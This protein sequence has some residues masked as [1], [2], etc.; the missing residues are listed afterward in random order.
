LGSHPLQFAH[1]SII[2]AGAARVSGFGDVDSES[3]RGAS[4]KKRKSNNA[5]MSKLMF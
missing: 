1:S 4:K 2:A 3:Q 5:K